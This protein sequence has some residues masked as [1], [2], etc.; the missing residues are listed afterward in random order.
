[1]PFATAI[2]DGV[3]L[4]GIRY[5]DRAQFKKGQPGYNNTLDMLVARR[6]LED[7]ILKWPVHLPDNTVARKVGSCCDGPTVNCSE[8]TWEP[9]DHANYL[10]LDDA[11]MGLTLATRMAHSKEEIAWVSS[12]HALFAKHLQDNDGL[13]THGYNNDKAERS[14]CKW[15]RANGWAMMSHVEHL[16]ALKRLGADT[17]QALALLTKHAEGL[18]KVQSADGRWRQVLNET[19]T[20][21]ETS[22]TSMNVFGI[23]SA[24]KEGWLDA[25]KFTVPV[26]KAWE[27]LV[28]SVVTADG[29]VTGVCTGTCIA[30]TIDYYE[31]RSTS[32]WAASNGGVGAS[33]RAA[34]AMA[35]LTE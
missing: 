22:A 28:A 5:W 20:F 24:V 7:Y 27:S 33:L 13:Y 19:S 11:F 31:H 23:A 32:Y 18:L 9:T 21:L 35:A 16:R 10:W 8:P 25:A 34:A 29:N 6:I 17:A 4:L 30:D 3:G 2:G 15:G 14:C 1:M 12:Q 26:T